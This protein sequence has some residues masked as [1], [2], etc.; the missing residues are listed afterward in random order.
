MNRAFRKGA[1]LLN[2]IQ[3]ARKLREQFHI[4]WLGQSGFLVQWQDRH[5]LI[6]PYLSDSLTR[7]YADTDKPHVRITEQVVEPAK[8][9]F[10]N[11]VSSSHN[12]TDHLDVETLRPLMHVNEAMPVIVP[13]ANQAFAS[14]R[15]QVPP[16]RLTPIDAGQSIEAGVFTIHA[17]PAAHNKLERDEQGRYKY[18]GYVFTFGEFA[19]YHSGDT[20][21]YDGLAER[22]KHFN[23]DVAMLPINGNLPERR[24]AGNLNGHEA[25]ELAEEI[26]AGVV[27]PCHFD[28]FAFNTVSP[29][30]FQEECEALGQRY[31]IM[32]V[33]ERWSS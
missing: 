32:Q 19:I 4:W 8:L 7:K 25:A 22:L 13:S 6:D 21:L 29:E 33:G 16:G 20:L 11:V 28:M 1:D 5:L 14:D 15:L 27:I 3:A 9:D 31:A 26:A 10:I 12:H 30:S 24:V 18:L 17:L 23:L 2:D